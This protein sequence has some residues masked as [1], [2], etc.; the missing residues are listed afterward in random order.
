[1]ASIKSMALSV[2]SNS[3]HIKVFCLPEIWL[4]NLT[5]SVIL[6]IVANDTLKNIHLLHQNSTFKRLVSFNSKFLTQIF[7]NF[8]YVKIEKLHAFLLSETN[9]TFASIDPP[10]ETCI[11]C[12]F[13]PVCDD[14][15][16]Q[17]IIICLLILSVILILVL[18]N[19]LIYSFIYFD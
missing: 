10:S 19:S 8:F 2:L 9:L 3:Y 11:S 18:L 17:L 7:A 13:T 16:S 1:M 5:T 14:E 4:E 15:V 6:F 12:Y